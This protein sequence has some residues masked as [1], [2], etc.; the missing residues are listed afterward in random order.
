MKLQLLH[1]AYKDAPLTGDHDQDARNVVHAI[2]QTLIEHA[3]SPRTVDYL[4][5]VLKE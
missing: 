3:E 1:N 5:G 4:I 2:L